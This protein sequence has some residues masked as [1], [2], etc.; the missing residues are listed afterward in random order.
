MLVLSTLENYVSNFDVISFILLFFSDLLWF[1]K[2]PH[3][4]SQQQKQREGGRSRGS[5]FIKKSGD[6]SINDSMFHV[7]KKKR[8]GD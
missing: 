2:T 1:R 7:S 5:S 3:Q 8:K 4:N 6:Q